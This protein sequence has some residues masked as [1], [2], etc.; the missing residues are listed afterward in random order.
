VL[1]VCS[2][3]WGLP[4]AG[5]PPAHAPSSSS[6]GAG[7]KKG[8]AGGKGSPSTVAGGGVPD[9]D[10]SNG[11]KVRPYSCLSPTAPSHQ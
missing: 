10:S 9:S 7:G 1:Q 5:A 8:D 6:S 3:P 2:V 11:S 4:H